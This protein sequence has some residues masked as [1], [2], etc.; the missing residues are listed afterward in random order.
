M[1][2]VRD[3]RALKRRTAREQVIKNRSQP[4][5]VAAPTD[6][7]M[8][9]RRLLGRHVIRRTEHLAGER[10]TGI[11]IKP[12]A[13]FAELHASRAGGGPSTWPESVRLESPSSRR[14]RPKSVTRG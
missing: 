13:R 7:L 5:H 3:G 1:H 11:P 14:A 4:V 9:R 6:H 8:Q 2:R 12:G 10:E